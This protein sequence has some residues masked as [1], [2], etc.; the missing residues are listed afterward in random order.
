LT[1]AITAR[2]LEV[3]ERLYEFCSDNRRSPTLS[4]LGRILGIS[5]EAVRKHL[6]A[7]EA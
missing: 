3:F 6:V 4:E 5:R 7:L 1:S 2:Q